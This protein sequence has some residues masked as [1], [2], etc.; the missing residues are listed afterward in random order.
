MKVQVTNET[1]ESPSV[2]SY[3]IFIGPVHTLN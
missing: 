3:F 2:Q 1:E